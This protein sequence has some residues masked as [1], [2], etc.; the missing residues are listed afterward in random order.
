M[1]SSHAFSRYRL[2]FIGISVGGFAAL[3]FALYIQYG[4]GLEPC[5]L[6]IFQ[7]V[8]VMAV[9]AIALVSG[10][11]NP[12]KRGG[13]VALF[14]IIVAA[15]VGSVFAGRQLWLQ[16]LPADQVPLCGPGLDYL[17][18]T[19]PFTS[20]LAK[21]FAGSGECAVVA[22]TLWGMSMPF[23]VILFFS[24]VILLALWQWKRYG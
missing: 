5:P 18:E 7:R 23:W 3:G 17:L 8:A 12:E 11:L 6:C 10:L 24:V 22:W 9:T 20:V 2:G 21:V 13:R 15:L 14:S 19:L 1:I 16:S 4:L